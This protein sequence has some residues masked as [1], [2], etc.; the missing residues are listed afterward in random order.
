MPAGTTG[1]GDSYLVV[2]PSLP[3]FANC[4]T[5]RCQLFPKKL[6]KA[7]LIRDSKT[8]KKGV[9]LLALGK[10]AQSRFF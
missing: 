10:A 7:H 4:A 1:L 3:R 5:N 9:I 2:T 6:S 8:Y